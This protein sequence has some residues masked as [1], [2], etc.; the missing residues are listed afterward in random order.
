MAHIESKSGHISIGK[1]LNLIDLTQR[2][3]DS[4]MDIS[5]EWLDKKHFV[6]LSPQRFSWFSGITLNG[7]NSLIEN[8]EIDFISFR[9]KPYIPVPTWRYL[10]TV[11]SASPEIKEEL[12]WKEYDS[13]VPY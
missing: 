3:L 9:K 5:C 10:R 11:E 6:F 7:V 12:L 1:K 2:K 8:D 4:Q 13:N